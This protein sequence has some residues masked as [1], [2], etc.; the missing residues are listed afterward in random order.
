MPTEIMCDNGKQFIGSKVSRFLEDHNIKEIVS[1]PYHPCGN[2]Q[3][4]S[5]NK[6]IPQNLKK[7]LTDAKGKWKEILPKVLWAYRTISKSCTEATPFSLVNGAKALIPV[8]VGEP[9]LSFRYATEESNDEAMSASLKLLDERRKV[10]LVRLAAQKQRIKRTSSPRA[11]SIQ[12]QEITP[13]RGLS[14]KTNS[15]GLD[16]QSL[17]AQKPIRQCP[18]LKGN[19]QPHSGTVVPGKPGWLGY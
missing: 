12:V 13:T 4:K 11:T 8:K 5:M 17:G 9:S 14:S 19:G 3:A 7:R 10:A 1:T 18:N 2:G 16:C 15:D 6:T